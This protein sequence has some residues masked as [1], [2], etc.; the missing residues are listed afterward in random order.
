MKKKEI[1]TTFKAVRL[2]LNTLKDE[3][4]SYLFIGNEGNQFVIS[5]NTADIA[6]Q[7]LFAMIRYPVV[8]ELIKTCATRVDE[9]EEK[10]GDRVRT[11]PLED[12]IEYNS[13]N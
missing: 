3:E 10:Y 9:I 5:G 4:A 8:K 11:A 2:T 13:G 6:A 12:L 1:E 7:I